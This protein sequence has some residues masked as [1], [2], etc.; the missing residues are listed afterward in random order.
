TIMKSGD[1]GQTWTA[2]TLDPSAIHNNVGGPGGPPWWLYSVYPGLGIGAG[3]YVASQL[4][5][6]PTDPQAVYSAGRSGLW[7][8]PDGGANWYPMVAKLGVTINR[9]IAVDARNPSVVDVA[10]T[11]WGMLTSSDALESV[12][13]DHPP[14]P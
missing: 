13:I 2:V 9:S 12:A 5:V 3:F 14:L 1:G 11:D 8:S 10:D 6:D 4:L 7:K